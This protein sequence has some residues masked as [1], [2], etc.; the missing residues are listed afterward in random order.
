ML[1]GAIY[2]RMFP[3]IRVTLRGP[4]DP[5]SRYLVLLDI[6]P[7]DMK[8]YRYAYHRSSW[9]IAGKA[10]PPAPYRLYTHPDS[11]LTTQATNGSPSSSSA[12]RT[13]CDCGSTGTCHLDFLRV[14]SSTE[15]GCL[16]AAKAA[17]TRHTSIIDQHQQPKSTLH[18]VSFEKLKLT[19]NV[20]DNNG[21]VRTF[22]LVSNL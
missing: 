1:C 5:M 3:T 15:H 8:R 19:N 16:S 18:S 12:T 7:V 20:M 6:V 21:H 2:R 14:V 4:L 9:L 13:P 11:P 22:S 17:G 10:D